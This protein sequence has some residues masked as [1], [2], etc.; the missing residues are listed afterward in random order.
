MRR[1]FR[2][3]LFSAVHLIFVLILLTAGL[4]LLLSSFSYNLN[5][6]A[7]NAL[8]NYPSIFINLG[9]FLIAMSALLIIGF[10]NTYK[11]RYIKIDAGSDPIFINEKILEN[12]LSSY[13]KGVFP[14][15]EKEPLAFLD[16]KGMLEIV[17]SYPKTDLEMSFLTKK[18]EK[19]IKEILIE[20][21][22]YK[23]SFILTFSET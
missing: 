15:E 10:Y 21:F 4:F 22:G 3:S 17:L 16:R 14:S 6:I 12:Y 20:K 1:N 9:S 23:K 18:L 5:R 19:E 7:I 2:F 11:G 8:L 13:W